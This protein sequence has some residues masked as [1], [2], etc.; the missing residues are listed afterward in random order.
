MEKREWIR[1]DEGN[2]QHITICVSLFCFL[3]FLFISFYFWLCWVFIAVRGLSL[4]VVSGGYSLLL[5]TGFLLQ[6]FLFSGSTGSRHTG[7]VVMARK[8][9]SVGSVAVAQG[10]SY[11][12]A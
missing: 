12:I 5:C 3:N 8:L 11:P 4:V 6:W 10:L 2:I 7:P 1:R 9:Y